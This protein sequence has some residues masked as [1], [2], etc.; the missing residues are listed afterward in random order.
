L[1]FGL[2][3]A[4]HGAQ[5]LFGSFGGYG[6]RATGEMFESLGFRPGKPT[7]A[8]AG[9]GELLGGLAL[10][11]GVFTPLA[12]AV[13]IATMLVAIFAVHF[14]KGFFA[15]NGGYE[16]PFL[17]AVVAVALS[18]AGPGRFSLDELAGFSFEYPKWG[19]I[20]LGL[21]LAGA[22][23]PLFGRFVALKRRA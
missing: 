21:G 10:A 22:M 2:S 7:A 3:M 4:A 1:A 14:E 8:L 9:V 11:F 18:F 19:F 5:K 13:V 17:V 6:L 15:Q 16:L 12:G 20:A 23:P